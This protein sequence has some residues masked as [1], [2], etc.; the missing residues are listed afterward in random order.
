M[1]ER[2][3]S[4]REGPSWNPSTTKEE[5]SKRALPTHRV[6]GG[7]QAEPHGSGEAQGPGPQG[8]LQPWLV[9]LSVSACLRVS[10]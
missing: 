5:N 2:L 8:A 7:V 9:V 3:P 6:N 1:V 4:L 10:E